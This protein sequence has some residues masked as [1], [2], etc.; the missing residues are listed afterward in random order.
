MPGTM[1][2]TATGMT[3]K[4]GYA[5][6]SQHP[7]NNDSGLRDFLN[8]TNK[9][10]GDPSDDVFGEGVHDEGIVSFSQKLARSPW[11]PKILSSPLPTWLGGRGD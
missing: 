7:V 3:Y 11:V 9:K 5:G 8:K 6:D 2:K 1:E 4:A 10:P